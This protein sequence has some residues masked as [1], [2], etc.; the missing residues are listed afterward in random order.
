MALVDEEQRVGRKVVEQ[1]RWRLAG[2]ASRK[3]ARV[4][5]DPLAVADLGHHLDVEPGPLLQA[6]RLD[7]TVRGPEHREAIDQLFPDRLDGL[8]NPFARGDIVALGIHRQARHAA[9]DLS[10][11]RVEP[12]QVLDLVVEE[13]DAHRILLGLC[14][15][16]VD[17]L[18]ANA[19]RAAV[20]LDLVSRV[21][22]LR[23]APEDEAL[24]D[25]VAPHQMQHHL[26]VGGRIAEAVDRRD[27]GHDDA[28]AVLQQRLGR[29]QPHLLDVVV[30]RRILLDVRVGRGHVCLGLVVVVVGDEVLDGVVREEIAHLSVEL[31]GQCLVGSEHQ[32]GPSDLLDD[33]RHRERLSGAGDAKQ[34]L[35]GE[36]GLDPFDELL[37][38]G[39]L[40]TGGGE[41]GDD[42]Q[43]SRAHGFAPRIA[44][45]NGLASTTPVILTSGA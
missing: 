2:P 12:A 25:G 23:E 38:R 27:G 20:Q 5:L 7:E 34:R 39:G 24:V 29:R 14:R 26:V 15:I 10:G 37:D 13:L 28:V 22:Q 42:G 16:H 4:V 3:E 30:D 19:V 36:P 43:G 31:C 35:V 18:A 17:D 32:G 33:L 1:G 8:H 21:L 40:V 45:R 44:G 11:Q 41:I 9:H 6:L